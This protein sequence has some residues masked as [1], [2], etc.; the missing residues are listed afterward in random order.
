MIDYEIDIL[1]LRGLICTP[2]HKIK[3]CIIIRFRSGFQNVK[4][5]KQISIKLS[6]Q[7]ACSVRRVCISF[8]EDAGFK[9]KGSVLVAFADFPTIR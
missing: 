7:S 1:I 6:I 5:F 9:T 8:V 2:Y 4:H 3:I